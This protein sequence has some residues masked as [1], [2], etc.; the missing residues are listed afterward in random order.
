MAARPP[1][2]AGDVS[3]LLLGMLPFWLARIRGGIVNGA[4]RMRIVSQRS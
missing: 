4:R 1:G 3:V 2:V